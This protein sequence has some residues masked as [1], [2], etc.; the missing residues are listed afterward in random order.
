[1]VYRPSSLSKGPDREYYA[2][3]ASRLLRCGLTGLAGVALL[4]VGAVGLMRASAD[5]AAGERTAEEPGD[6]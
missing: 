5:G 1:M 4:T 6:S 3:A 2:A